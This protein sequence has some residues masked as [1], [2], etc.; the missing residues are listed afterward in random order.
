MNFV[1]L[2]DAETLVMTAVQLSVGSNFLMP[3]TGL[4]GIFGLKPDIKF[5]GDDLFKLTGSAMMGG[6]GLASKK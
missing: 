4:G 5:S 3:T 6:G 1:L 2:C